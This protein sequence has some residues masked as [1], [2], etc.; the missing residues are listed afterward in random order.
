MGVN[1]EFHKGLVD[2]RAEHLDL[3]ALALVHEAC[4]L[5]DVR[6]VAR[7]DGRHVFRRIVGFQPCRLEGD[8]RIACSVA[9]IEGI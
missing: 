3:H 2:I 8:P 9:L 7:Q 6:A 5:G 1:T 4:E